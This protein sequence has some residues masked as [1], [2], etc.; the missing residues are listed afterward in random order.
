V[1]FHVL[2]FAVSLRDGLA[3]TTDEKKSHWEKVVGGV[4]ESAREVENVRSQK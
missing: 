1:S 2:P 3:I 4:R